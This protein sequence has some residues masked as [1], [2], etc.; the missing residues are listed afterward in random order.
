MQIGIQKRGLSRCW[1]GLCAATVLGATSL[2]P[3]SAQSVQALG[4][5]AGEWAARWWQW[6]L[7]VPADRNP[8]SD[9][10]GRHCAQ[11]Q[12][13]SVWFLAGYWGSAGTPVYRNCHVPAGKAIF[14][15]VV[16]TV[17]ITSIWDDPNIKEDDIRACLAGIAGYAFRCKGGPGVAGGGMARHAGL[18]VTIKP[19]ATPGDGRP[20]VFEQPI[21]RAQSP[22]FRIANFPDNN[23]LGMPPHGINNM[24][25]YADGQWVLLPP[26]Q[27]G[28]HLLSFSAAEEGRVVQKITYRLTVLAAP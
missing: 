19:E 23:M 22:L 20:V 4:V 21:V 2:P 17:W 8:M 1:T 28:V 27:P 16:N 12:Q 3:A 6:S 15:P 10:D 24:P 5:P 14:F 13:G 26:Q 9:T 11:G 18:T 25:A 7:G